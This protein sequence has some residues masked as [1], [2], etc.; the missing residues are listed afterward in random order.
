M[1]RRRWMQFSLRGFLVVL[2]IGCLWLGWQVNRAR[3]QREA[4]QAIEALGGVVVYD[5]QPKLTTQSK[6][7]WSVHQGRWKFTLADGN[8]TPDGPA[9]LRRIVGEDLFQD[10]SGV[11]FIGVST[12]RSRFTEN[13]IR[14][15]IPSLK[16]LRTLRTLIIEGDV[17]AEVMAELK[18]ALPACDVVQCDYYSFPKG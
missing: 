7:E 17:S 10:V 3:E 13:G 1:P 15:W 18:A 5:W 6:G 12:V 2:T 9:W 8:A 4:V 14:S 16:R 11:V